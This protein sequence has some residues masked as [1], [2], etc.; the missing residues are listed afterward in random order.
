MTIIQGDSG[1]ELEVLLQTKI[2]DPVTFWLDAHYCAD[3]AALPDKWTPLKEELKSIHNHAVKNHIILVDDF[4]C[5][6]NT[7][8]DVGTQRPVDFPGKEGLLQ[9]LREI[10]SNYRIEFLN[11]VIENDV[12]AAYVE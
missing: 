6:D 3:G 7:H 5:M 10:N 11:G 8:F 12:V 1:K 2:S 9:T 4:R